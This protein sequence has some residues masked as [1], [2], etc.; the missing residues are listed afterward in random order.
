MNKP[1]IDDRDC[2]L[3]CLATR[4]Q[5]LLAGGVVTT[6]VL[7]SGLEG[8]GLD[9][10]EAL[11]SKYPRRKIGQVSALKLDAPVAFAY[12]SKDVKNILVKLGVPAGGGVGPKKDIV[13]FNP[14]CTHMGG[15]LEK[16]YRPEHKV[17]GQ[18]PYHLSTFDLTRH[19]LIVSG[20]ASMS[21]PQVVLE[22]KGDDIYATGV[23]GL[24]YGRHSNV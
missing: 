10:A 11:V 12:P 5:F 17:L 16:L 20:H 14:V 23:S 13:A 21:L 22:V 7:L 1:T 3:S 15:N 6:T 24:I 8:L 4:R 9:R 19:G 2:L 18:C